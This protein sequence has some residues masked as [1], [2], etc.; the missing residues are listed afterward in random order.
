MSTSEFSWDTIKQYFDSGHGAV[1]DYLENINPECIIEGE[2]NYLEQKLS[3]IF[4]VFRKP[5]DF[6]I[7]FL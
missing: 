6:Q 1:N 7:V 4:S 5:T 3:Y 2:Y